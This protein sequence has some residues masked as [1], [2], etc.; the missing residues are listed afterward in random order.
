MSVVPGQDIPHQHLC[1]LDHQLVVAPADRRVVALILN[2]NLMYFDDFVQFLYEVG[3][4]GLFR[5]H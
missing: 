2:S 4:F 1:I 3:D 5:H